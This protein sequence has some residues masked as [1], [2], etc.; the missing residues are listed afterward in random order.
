[1]NHDLHDL[2]SSL[3]GLRPTGADSALLTR[4]ESAAE[5]TLTEL[6]AAELR[7]ESTL[8]GHRP[9]ALPV[10][11]FASLENVLASSPTGEGRAHRLSRSWRRPGS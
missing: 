2:E 6:T 9:L 8:R 1:M 10:E 11:F 7:L 4:L 3:A 5:G